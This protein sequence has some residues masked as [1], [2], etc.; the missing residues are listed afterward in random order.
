MARR[1]SKVCVFIHTV[2]WT[3]RD[4]SWRDEEGEEEEPLLVDME[5]FNVSTTGAHTHTHKPSSTTLV[6]SLQFNNKYNCPLGHE[7]TKL[8]F[9][10]SLKKSARLSLSNGLFFCFGGVPSDFDAQHSRERKRGGGDFAPQHAREKEGGGGGC[11]LF[12]HC[13]AAIFVFLFGF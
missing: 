3:D 7:H 12:F 6:F 8:Y 11:G 13:C 9:P 5:I 1:D 2:W 4:R 10:S